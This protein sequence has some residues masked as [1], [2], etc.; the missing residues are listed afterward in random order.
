MDSV[1]KKTKL[2]KQKVVIVLVYFNQVLIIEVIDDFV[3]R[4]TLVLIN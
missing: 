4:I 3:V 1:G 2:I